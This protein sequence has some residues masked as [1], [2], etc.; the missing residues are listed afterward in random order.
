MYKFLVFCFVNNMT[1]IFATVSCKKS[2]CAILL[3]VAVEGKERAS[4]EQFMAI[5]SSMDGVVP[6]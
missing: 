1:T 2:T 4:F 5:V 3:L 6:F